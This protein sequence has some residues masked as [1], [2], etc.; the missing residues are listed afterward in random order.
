[1]KVYY[2]IQNSKQ[3][4]AILSHINPIHAFRSCV[5]RPI[6]MLSSH[7]S[8]NLP[9]RLF[10]SGLSIKGVWTS[11]LP[12]LCPVQPTF[13]DVILIHTFPIYCPTWVEICARDLH[14]MLSRSPGIS[15]KLAKG[16]LYSSYGHKWNYIMCAPWQYKKC[17]HT[18]RVCVCVC[19]CNTSQS[20]QFSILFP[21]PES[22][23]C[24]V[25]TALH[26]VS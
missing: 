6:L 20:T 14:M 25:S 23:V 1:M 2:S 12:H 11:L 26:Y 21:L 7:L 3:F 19:V 9:R 16:R 5:L 15:R 24:N 13:S 22:L 10:F 17:T 18:A 8:P 4:A